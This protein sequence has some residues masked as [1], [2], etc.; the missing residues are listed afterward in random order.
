MYV[1]VFQ[2]VTARNDKKGFCFASQGVELR[3]LG[4][5]IARR[6]KI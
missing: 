3:M 4:N 2:R 6:S 1:S 5:D